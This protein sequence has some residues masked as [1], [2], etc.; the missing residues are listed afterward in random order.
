[1]N[2]K[3]VRMQSKPSLYFLENLRHPRTFKSLM[4]PINDGTLNHTLFVPS[5][6]IERYQ[7]DLPKS[8]FRCTV[9]LSNPE[10]RE[11]HGNP[12]GLTAN[13]TAF[14]KLEKIPLSLSETAS[15]YPDGS[16]ILIENEI[17]DYLREQHS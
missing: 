9:S 16:A 11:R 5:Q 10:H 2:I 4:Y 14:R 1:G 8:Y 7:N 6:A 17:V 12:F 3:V 15:L 13:I